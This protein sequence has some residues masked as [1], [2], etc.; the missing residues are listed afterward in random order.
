MNTE[1]S[2]AL[3]SWELPDSLWEILE[4]LIPQRKSH[5][6]RPRNVNFKKI[7]AGIFY[8][9]RTGIQWQAL[10]RENFGPPSTVY[11]YFKTWADCGIFE[12]MWAAANETYDELSQLDWQWQSVDGA[13]TKAPL[14]GEATLKSHRP[15]QEWHE[16]VFANF[17]QWNSHC[18]C[19]SGSQWGRF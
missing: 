1:N 12:K 19:F 9:L 4:P 7:L 6:G 10:P 16:T 8:V 15:R 18:Y 17:R 2:N 14:G 11:H 5:L 13:M 3:L